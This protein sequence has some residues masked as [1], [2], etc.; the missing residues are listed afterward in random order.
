MSK[1]K[2]FF[3]SKKDSQKSCKVDTSAF[4]APALT[5]LEQDI[6]DKNDEA[7]AA[8]TDEALSETLEWEVE[9]PNQPC[10]TQT[11]VFDSRSK[12][13]FDKL[14]EKKTWGKRDGNVEASETIDQNDETPNNIKDNTNIIKNLVDERNSFPTLGSS[15][16]ADETCNQEKVVRSKAL[17]RRQKKIMLVVTFLQLIRI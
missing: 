8:E 12:P 10:V 4:R 17:K 9:L 14:K 2:D 5:S 11:E 13:D 7:N 15:I 6:F 3:R 16:I 1:L